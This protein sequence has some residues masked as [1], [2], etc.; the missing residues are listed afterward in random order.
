MR[1]SLRACFDGD[2]P[3]ATRTS[4]SLRKELA[5]LLV[6]TSTIVYIPSLETVISGDVAYND[7]HQW[8]AQTDH[9]KRTQRWL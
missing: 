8:L 2:R 5:W 3:H 7:I 4:N 1:E 6:C 9:E